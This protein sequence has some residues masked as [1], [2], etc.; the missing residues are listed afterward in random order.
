LEDA[1]DT[2]T[3]TC[4]IPIHADVFPVIS[5][6]LLTWLGVAAAA[7]TLAGNI[8]SHVSLWLIFD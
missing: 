6:S 2:F 8:I 1:D 7:Q 5:A 4:A 3:Q